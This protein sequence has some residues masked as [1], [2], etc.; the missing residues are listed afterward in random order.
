MVNIVDRLI[1]S[2]GNA[3]SKMIEYLPN[4]LA[5]IIVLIVGYFIGDLVGKAV[6]KLVDKFIQRPLENTRIGKSLKESG[7]DFSKLFGGLTKAFIIVISIVIAI[8]YLELTGPIGTLVSDIAYFL[9][10]LIG[11]IAVLAIGI[12]L[13]ILLSKFFTSLLGFVSE[14]HKSF[15]A[16]LESIVVLA[17]TVLAI[18]IAV[19]LIFYYDALLNYI[20]LAAPGFITASIILIVA[21]IIGDAIASILDKTLDNIVDKPLGRTEFGRTFKELGIDLSALL[22]GLVKAFIIVVAIVAA[23]EAMQ[24]TGYAGATIHEIALF[25]PKLIGAITILTLGLLLA[26]ALA[27]YI[28]SFLKRSFPENYSEISSI[29]ENFILLGLISVIITIALNTLDLQG[30]LVYPLIVGALVIAIGIFVAGTAVKIIVSEYPEFKDFAPYLQFIVLLVFLIIGLGAIFSQFSE[31]TRVIETISWGIAI[32]FAV[33]LVP[34]LFYL[35]RTGFR[36]AKK[37]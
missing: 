17:I 34:I 4:V 7:I 15:V 35:A 37:E 8:N 32:A 29:I 21:Y 13:G 27:K 20:T 6:E 26:V 22:A 28:G 14:R 33:T 25:L 11:G 16:L 18:A 23:V 36:W 9:P 24:L 1:D 12:P 2:I 5:S 10:R 19:N 3:V 31:A 30:S